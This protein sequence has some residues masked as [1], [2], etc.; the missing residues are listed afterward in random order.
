MK[1]IR[2][3]PVT[4]EQYLRDHIA[5]SR[6]QTLVTF[7][8]NDRTNCSASYYPCIHIHMNHDTYIGQSNS[9]EHSN[10]NCS[11][12]THTIMD[13]QQDNAGVHNPN[14]SKVVD[15]AKKNNVNMPQIEH[16]N[17]PKII[18]TRSGWVSHRPQRLGIV[19]EQ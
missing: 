9:V 7:W 11:D 16:S 19:E 12:K 6:N 3:I 17:R 1:H 8:G 18:W 2:K 14:M 10:D 15:N 13:K 5:K 4:V